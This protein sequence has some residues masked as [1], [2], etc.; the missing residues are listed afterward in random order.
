ML[1][2]TVNLALARHEIENLL[3]EYADA[4]DR[5]DFSSIGQ[6]F[7]Q[8]GSLHGADGTPLAQGSA[9][10]EAFYRSTVLIPDGMST[11]GTQ[12]TVSNLMLT[13]ENADTAKSKA[14]FSVAQY[15]GGGRIQTIICGQ[16]VTRWTLNENR[17]WFAEHHMHPR[18]VGDLSQ[19]VATDVAK[20]VIK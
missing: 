15:I 14:N 19:H 6:M 16:Y 13:L 11:P 5:A 20:Q 10:I 17:W 1:N 4:V 7:R 18:L 2:M 9:A 12:H 8:N 3:Y